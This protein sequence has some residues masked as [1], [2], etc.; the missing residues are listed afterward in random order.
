MAAR[1]NELTA[2]RLRSTGIQVPVEGLCQ[3]C[4]HTLLRMSS[5][6]RERITPHKR[7]GVYRAGF[8]VGE[9]VLL[10]ALRLVGDQLKFAQ[11]LLL[12]MDFKI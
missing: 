3:K 9:G 4:A 11:G 10:Q 5:S 7:R 1:C 8:S 6:W 2:S 12:G